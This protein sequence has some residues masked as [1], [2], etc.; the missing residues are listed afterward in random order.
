M[1]SQDNKDEL[2]II[3][4]LGVNGSGKTTSIGKL[5]AYYKDQGQDVLV[6]A[7]DTFRAAAHDQIDI[8]TQRAGV[9][10]IVRPDVSDPAA[11]F[12]RRCTRL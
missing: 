12:M 8:W 3:L 1:I 2:Q 9:D 5:A 7:A 4:V 11:V 10:L 6:V